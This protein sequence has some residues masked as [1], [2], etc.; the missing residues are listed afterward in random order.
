MCAWKKSL[1]YLDISSLKDL[2]NYHDISVDISRHINLEK[3]YKL[4]HLFLLSI[5]LNFKI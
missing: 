1:K 5:N 3:N 4:K 2:V